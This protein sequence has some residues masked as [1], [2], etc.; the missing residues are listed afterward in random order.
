VLL[1]L[2]HGAN[3]TDLLSEEVYLD[4][5][6]MAITTSSNTLGNQPPCIVQVIKVQ[7]C[8][9]N[10]YIIIS[11]RHATPALDQKESR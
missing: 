9:A 3:H 2:L 10:H 7:L 5:V 8:F 4:I 6:Y 1:G 11:Q